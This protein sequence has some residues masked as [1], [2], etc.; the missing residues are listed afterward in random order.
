MLDDLMP[1]MSAKQL[2]Q[3]KRGQRIS[4]GLGTG[5]TIGQ[6]EI[7]SLEQQMNQHQLKTLHSKFPN[8]SRQNNHLQALTEGSSHRIS[9]IDQNIARFK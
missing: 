5:V 3:K 9:F 1:A 8:L 2:V 6:A 4:A 7:D